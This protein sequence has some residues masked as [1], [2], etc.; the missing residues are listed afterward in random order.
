M[1]DASPL[2]SLTG[3]GVQFDSEVE[4]RVDVIDAKW[5][6]LESEMSGWP[7][8][9]KSCTTPGFDQQLGDVIVS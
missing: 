1:L 3:I 7:S 2:V 9:S 8:P 6:Q 4:R 5:L